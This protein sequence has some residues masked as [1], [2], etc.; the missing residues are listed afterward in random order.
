MVVDRVEDSLRNL[1]ARAVIEEDESRLL[2][3][4]RKERTDSIAG[5]IHGLGCEQRLFDHVAPCADGVIEKI[6]SPGSHPLFRAWMGPGA[7]AR[8]RPRIREELNP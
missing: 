1:R 4:R 8:S 5:E 3:Q 7:F 2:V 6:F